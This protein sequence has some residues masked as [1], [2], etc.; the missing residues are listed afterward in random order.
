MVSTNTCP[1]DR[2][3]ELLKSFLNG[4]LKELMSKLKAECGSLLLLDDNS[5]EIVLNSFYNSMDLPIRGLRKKACDGVAGKVL[6]MKQPVL[7]TDIKKDLRFKSNGFSHYNTR[8]FMSIPIFA[9]GNL[10]GLISLADKTKGENFSQLDFTFAS[11]VCRYACM[12][13]ENMLNFSRLRHEKSVLDREKSLLEKYASVGKLASCI[14]HQ[15]NNPLDGVIRFTNILL[16]HMDQNCVGNEY[17][18]EI[19]KGL[20]RIANITKSLLEFGHHFNPQDASKRASADVN[21]LL[22]ESVEMFS[23]RIS[24]S[25]SIIKHYRLKLPLVCDLGLAHVF[26]NII[27]NSLDAMPQGG[28]LEISTEAKK[29]GIEIVFKDTGCGIPEDFKEKI[30]EPFFTT[31]EKEKGSGLGLAICKEIVSRYHGEIKVESIMGIGSRFVIFIP[32]AGSNVGEK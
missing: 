30:F 13:I 8:S 23:P 9:D 5:E 12:I 6:Q 10:L 14:V 19:Q 16:S 25:V 1:D 4:T 15:I 22:D 3:E 20:F 21:R 28:K 17:L 24:N 2:V 27:K 7:V 26:V 11:S 18:S 32:T 31:K 29:K